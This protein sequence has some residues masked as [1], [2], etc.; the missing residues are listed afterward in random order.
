MTKQV[1]LWSVPEAALSVKFVFQFVIDYSLMTLRRKNATSKFFNWTNIENGP[2]GGW[3]ATTCVNTFLA[4]NIMNLAINAAEKEAEMLGTVSGPMP[5]KDIKEV[6]EKVWLPLKFNNAVPNKFD[7]QEV[8][9]FDSDTVSDQAHSSVKA[10]GGSD[11]EDADPLQSLT[12]Y[13]PKSGRLAV[14]LIQD[15]FDAEHE[16]SVKKLFD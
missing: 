9:G 5:K 12:G 14:E 16:A 11:V 2:H 7:E 8:E 13:L 3:T 15:L 1:A 4:H 6:L 10:A